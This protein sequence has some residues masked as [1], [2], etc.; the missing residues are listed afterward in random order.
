MRIV[1]RRCQR[2]ITE[3]TIIEVNDVIRDIEGE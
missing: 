2:L 3:R 1:Q